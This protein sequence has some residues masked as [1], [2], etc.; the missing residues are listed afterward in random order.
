MYFC[1]KAATLGLKDIL[2]VKAGPNELSVVMS[3]LSTPVR[4][5]LERTLAQPLENLP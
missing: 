4:W 2:A 5:E 1:S 3:K